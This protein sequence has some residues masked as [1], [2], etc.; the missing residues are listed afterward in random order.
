[1]ER[2]GEAFERYLGN[3]ITRIW[4]LIDSVVFGVGGGG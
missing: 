4:A 2:G 3:A 1:M